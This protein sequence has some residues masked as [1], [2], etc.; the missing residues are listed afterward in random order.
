MKILQNIYYLIPRY[1]TMHVLNK[2][3]FLSSIL[4]NWRK[5][6]KRNHRELDVF[7]CFS[8]NIAFDN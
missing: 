4:I 2:N 3:I 7:R 5:Q 1:K 6:Q 8:E